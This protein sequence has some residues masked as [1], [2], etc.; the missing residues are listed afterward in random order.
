MVV[1]NTLHC[2]CWAL[3]EIQLL[4]LWFTLLQ[5]GD[6]EH[7]TL[8]LLGSGGDI[9]VIVVVHIASVW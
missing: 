3:E 1:W 7:I 2:I 6:L 4:L 8:Y 5:Y 9:T